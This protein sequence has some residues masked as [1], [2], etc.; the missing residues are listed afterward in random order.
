MKLA[1][2]DNDAG[3]FGRFTHYDFL[4]M[5][6]AEAAL[7]VAYTLDAVWRG[8]GLAALIGSLLL[9]MIGARAQ[10]R[11]TRQPCEKCIGDMPLDA[12]A[13]AER[14]RLS[15]RLYHWSTSSV[16]FTLGVG[17]VAS[18]WLLPHWAEVVVL[19]G[20]SACMLASFVAGWRH[21][22]LQ[23]VCPWCNWRDWDDDEVPEPTPVP[24]P[25]GA[26]TA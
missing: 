13:Q 14:K 10:R 20:L 26:K 1:D 16:W 25:A 7:I 21:R 2:P 17:C 9:F 11:H 24:D 3:W 4:I 23:P 22:P 12:Q 18:T 19:S 6:A 15:L 5:A 8:V